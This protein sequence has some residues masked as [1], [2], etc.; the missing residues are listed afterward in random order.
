VSWRTPIR[1]RADY[2]D[3]DT[4]GRTEAPM[5]LFFELLIGHVLADFVLQTDTMATAK[6]RHWRSTPA[7]GTGFPPWYY[8]LSAHALIHGGT[9][10]VIT[11]LWYLG[12][13]ETVLHSVIDFAKSEHKIN[14]HTDQAL[15]IACKVAYCLAILP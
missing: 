13:I 7:H 4:D 2:T 3:A 5:I 12:I 15:H 14:F 1:K 9:V 10:Y 11:G 8:W 6:S